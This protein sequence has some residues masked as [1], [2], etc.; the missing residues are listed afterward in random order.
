MLKRSICEEYFNCLYRNS[1]KD[2]SKF[3][4]ENNVRAS[5]KNIH[6]VPNI[7]II[8]FIFDKIFGVINNL[9]GDNNITHPV[10]NNY[11]HL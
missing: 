3:D 1:I 10:K 7:N 2:S 4:N 11:N 6:R 5:M 9:S 8:N